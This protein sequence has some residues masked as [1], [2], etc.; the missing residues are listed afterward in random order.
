MSPFDIVSGTPVVLYLQ[1]PKEKMWGILLAML[2]NGIVIRGIDLVAF[3]DW[4]RQEAHGDERLLGLT[5]IF[6]PLTRVERMERDESVGTV[7]S[8]CE[9]FAHAVGRTV[10]QAMGFAATDRES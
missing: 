4:M 1:A 3:E 9:R 6:F 5:T 10:Q 7:I 2:P 8:Y